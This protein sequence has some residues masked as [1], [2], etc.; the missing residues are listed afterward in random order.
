[1]K[2]L[3]DT[4][5][6]MLWGIVALSMGI[7]TRY[8]IGGRQYRRR[9]AGGLQHFNTSCFAWVLLV[10]FLEWVFKWASYGLILLGLF[11]ILNA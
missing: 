9:G 11:L 7:I 2:H 3:I 1:M 4:T 6:P 8:I 10:F 5:D